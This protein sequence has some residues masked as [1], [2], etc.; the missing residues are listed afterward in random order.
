MSGKQPL[1]ENQ[2]ITP[3][4]GLLPE[5]AIRPLKDRQLTDTDQPPIKP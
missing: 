5:E 2:T 4:G 3:E 1:G